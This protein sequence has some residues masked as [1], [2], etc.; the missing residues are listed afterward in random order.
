MNET[1]WLRPMT[2]SEAGEMG[3]FRPSSRTRKVQ[4][5]E[6]SRGVVRG[7]LASLVI[8]LFAGCVSMEP[9]FESDLSYLEEPDRSPADPAPSHLEDL[10]PAEPAPSF[11]EDLFE[12]VPP[13][14]SDYDLATDGPEELRN[15][16]ESVGSEERSSSFTG[17]SQF[18]A[19][20]DPAV[21]SALDT[22][23]E[24]Q[25]AYDALPW[26]RIAF[27]PKRTMRQGIEET[28]VVRISR[29]NEANILEGWVD[30]NSVTGE[31]RSRDGNPVR[32]EHIK[33]SGAMEVELVA[34][35]PEAFRIQPPGPL[36]QAIVGPYT[37]FSWLVTPLKRGR[38]VLR[39]QVAAEIPTAAGVKERR[40]EVKNADIEVEVNPG[41]VA[42]RFWSENWQWL[43][44]SPFVVGFFGWAARRLRTRNKGSSASSGSTD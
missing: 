40:V 4:R 30:S 15:R 8:A 34:A 33:V 22:G 41:F 39:L 31:T 23:E 13:G 9:D 11:E 3:I 14:D 44:G 25:R 37:D 17:N 7:G 38:Y 32:V 2:P 28:V 16:R 10:P 12:D 24:L 36:R 43:A 29:N 35:D 20:S 27:E 6:I 1:R 18:P 26:G 21:P 19:Q 5:R 42:K